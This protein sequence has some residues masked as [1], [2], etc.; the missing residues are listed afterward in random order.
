MPRRDAELK[1][2]LLAT[3]A[4]EADEHLGA[5]IGHLVALAANPPADDARALLETTFREMH[6]LKGAARSVGQRDIERVCASCEALLSTL[7]RAPTLPAPPV[8]ALLEEAVTAVARLV[9]G[10]EGAAVPSDLMARLQLATA[11]PDMVAPLAAAPEAV[12][13]A[14]APASRAG[15]IRL[16]TGDLDTLLRRG[17]ELLAIKLAAEA[18][19]A[20]AEDFTERLRRARDA[21]D[22]GAAL[23]ALEAPA[24][25][26]LTGLRRDRRAIDGA[27][28]GMLEQTRR[29]RMVPAASVLDLFPLMVRDLA[30]SQGKSVEWTA[31]GGELRVDRRVLEAIK[32]PLIHLVRNSVDHGLETRD[33]RVEAGKSPQG[34]IELTVRALEGGRLEMIVVDDGRGID[35]ARVQDAARRARIAGSDAGPL[36]DEEA[37]ALVFRSGLSTSFVITDVSGHGLGLAIVKEQVERLGGQVELSSRPRAGTTVRLVVPATIATF[38]GLLV[39]AGGQRFLLPLEAVERVTALEAD[40]PL[41]QHGRD[42]IRRDGEMLPCAALAS[43][44]GLEAATTR[45]RSSAA[46]ARSSPPAARG[47]RCSSTRCSATAR[48]WSRSSSRRSCA[49]AT[50]PPPA[51]SAP[52]SSC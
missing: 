47:P 36:S 10:G 26:M 31:N 13:L 41:A 34:R 1:A 28:D 7:T 18:W 49:S 2:R 11:E 4:V 46:R 21:E 24:R 25:A 37:L 16:P 52:A 30:H 20:G 3:F 33:E 35:P 45:R 8:I 19:V 44:L 6:T 48:C 32:D 5:L 38:R 51:C 23:R 12:P 14:G 15:T 9:A 43:V 29:V 42:V 22:P 50:S 27:I 39:R 17:E 40:E